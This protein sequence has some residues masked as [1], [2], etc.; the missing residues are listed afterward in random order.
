[1][2]NKLKAEIEEEIKKQVSAAIDV[3]EKYSYPQGDEPLSLIVEDASW[4]MTNFITQ[5]YA[6]LD[7]ELLA[8]VVDSLDA[9]INTQ[10]SHYMS[11]DRINQTLSKLKSA[12]GGGDE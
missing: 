3:C 12:T 2:T 6:V 4:N 1:M 8:E 9:V 5:N 7:K 10:H 11:F